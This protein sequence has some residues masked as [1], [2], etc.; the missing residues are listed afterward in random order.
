MNG[1]EFLKEARKLNEGEEINPEQANKL[2]F[3]GLVDTIDNQHELKKALDTAVEDLT[4]VIQVEMKARA[5]VDDEQD[6]KIDKLFQMGVIKF[7]IWARRNPN[8]FNTLLVFGFV[9]LSAW[10]VD[11]LRTSVLG[12]VPFLSDEWVELLSTGGR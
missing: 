10:M 6:K 8:K 12:F 3:A 9:A 5:L 1:F 4:G 7:N 2:L 11:P